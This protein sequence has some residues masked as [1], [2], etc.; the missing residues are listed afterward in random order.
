MEEGGTK[1]LNCLPG[2]RQML[3]WY[4]PPEKGQTIKCYCLSVKKQVLKSFC[5]QER[6]RWWNTSVGQ[7]DAERHGLS[8][9]WHAYAEVVLDCNGRGKSWSAADC[10]CW[11]GLR[12]SVRNQV[13]K[14]Y[15]LAG[16]RK[17]L[18]WYCLSRKKQALKF[19]CLSREGQVQIR[20]K[21]G[22]CWS[23]TAY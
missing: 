11:N 20:H 15:W 5:C 8:G 22:R 2:K 23:A 6:G 7:A 19:N 18:K 3:K 9:T 14:G 13:L 1:R 16:K 21:K 17:M 4:Y 12:L 10:Q